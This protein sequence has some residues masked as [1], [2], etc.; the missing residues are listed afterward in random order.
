MFLEPVIYSVAQIN[1]LIG[2]SFEADA[3]LHDVWIEGE[4]SNPRQYASGH[5]YFTLKD[6]RSQL[7]GVM[8]RSQT[9]RQ[10]SLPQHGDR[11]RAHGKISVYL[12]DGKYQLYADLFEPLNETGDLHRRFRQL[13]DKLEAEGLFDPQ[14]KRPLP[15]FPL[16]IGVVTS[17]Q[18]AAFQDIQNVLRR[19]Y[20]LAEVILSPTPVQGLDAAPQIVRALQRV[21]AFGVD[22]ILLARGGGSLEDLWCFND[23]TLARALRNTRAPVVTGVGHETD[24]TLVDGASDLRAPTPS[25]GA[26]LITPELDQLRSALSGIAA[27]LTEIVQADAAS[28]RHELANLSHK[29]R[30]LSPLPTVRSYRQR[31]DQQHERMVIA[32]RGKLAGGR[33]H[34]AAQQRALNLANPINLLAR[35]YALVTRAGDGKRL[36]N[37]LDAAP[38]TSI[39]V[40]LEH[41][42]LAAVVKDRT[43]D[44]LAQSESSEKEGS[45]EQRPT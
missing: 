3:R 43:L 14:I 21:D 41:G 28:R 25:A 44:N 18:A 6:E 22:V 16:R 45:S 30:L 40:Q 15:P 20:P 9:A 8:W 7:A 24:V 34:L 10:Q 17:P 2:Q 32:L 19:R 37:A 5:L 42:T 4:I 11:I 27:Q 35:G 29:L 31:I 39:T 33:Q 36:T 12:Q 26:E 1:A 23:E 38:G 13:W